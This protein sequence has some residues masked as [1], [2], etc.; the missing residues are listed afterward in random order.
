MSVSVGRIPNMEAVYY[1]GN[2]AAV[3]PRF[4]FWSIDAKNNYGTIPS[5]PPWNPT[6]PTPTGRSLWMNKNKQL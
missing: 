1:D 2:F 6:E 4:S 3:V 5:I